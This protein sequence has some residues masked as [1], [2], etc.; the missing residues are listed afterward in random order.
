VEV[1]EY[2]GSNENESEIGNHKI[3]YILKDIKQVFLKSI[4]FFADVLH[5]TKKF[6]LLDIKYTVCYF[7]V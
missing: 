6:Y 3:D 5:T 4:H 7:S 1:G 2:I